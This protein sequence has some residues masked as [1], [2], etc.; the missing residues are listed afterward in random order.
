M[1]LG[2]TLSSEPIILKDEKNQNEFKCFFQN[3][4]SISIKLSKEL[5]FNRLGY[6][7]WVNQLNERENLTTDIS[8]DQVI[9]TIAHELSHA[10]VNSIHGEYFGE[11]DGKRGHGKI[12]DD[13]TRRIEKMIKEDID[14]L[15][16]K[17]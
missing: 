13:F 1:T 4:R 3:I 17:T 2:V 5:F 14:F 7:V 10:V 8:F 12:H 15:E 11:Y 6:N 16:F 9:E